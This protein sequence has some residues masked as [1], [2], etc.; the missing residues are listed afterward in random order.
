LP[1]I[2]GGDLLL[3]DLLTF[4]LPPSP[5][6]LNDPG[7]VVVVVA[8]NRDPIEEECILTATTDDGSAEL[9]RFRARLATTPPE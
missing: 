1:N 9:R 2:C 7:V 6:L 8:M 4:E 3:I 5:P